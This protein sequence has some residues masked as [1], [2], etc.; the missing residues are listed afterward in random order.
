MQVG[1]DDEIDLLGF[2]IGAPQPVEEIRCNVVPARDGDAP[3]PLP[4]PGS[5]MI[6][7]PPIMIKNACTWPLRRPISSTKLGVNHAAQETA[8][9]W[10]L[11]MRPCSVAAA[12][13]SQVRKIVASPTCQRRICTSP[14]S[15]DP[16][17]HHRSVDFDHV[18]V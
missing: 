17:G 18:A 15:H 2:H 11:G 5:T 12:F 13:T 9:G 7:R 8:A 1:I 6:V 14:L 4:T 3:F 10:N 16:M